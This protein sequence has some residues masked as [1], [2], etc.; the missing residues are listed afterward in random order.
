MILS[1]KTIAS[2]CC[3]DTPMVSPFTNHQVNRITDTKGNE[4]RIVSYG[5]SSY[6]YDVRLASTFKIFTNIHSALIDPLAV[7]PNCFVEHEGDYCIIPPNSYV[8]G[9]TLECFHIPRDILALFLGKS[10]YARLAC[11]INITPIEPGF[12]G[13][14]VV[15]IANGSPLPL[16]VYA[17][18]G[19]AQAIFFKGDVPCEVSYADRAGKYQGQQGLTLARL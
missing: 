14:V 7:D 8:L 1:D 3:G 2:L 15:E 11:A 6:G 17:N 10:T 16:K 13:Q 12:I 19:I 5:R 4:Q 9:Y 18:Q